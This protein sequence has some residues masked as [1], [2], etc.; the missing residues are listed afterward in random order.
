[1][2]MRKVL[3]ALSL[4]VMALGGLAQPA[5]ADDGARPT[6][7]FAPPDPNALSPELRKVYDTSVRLLGGPYGPRMPMLQSPEVANEWSKLLDALGGTSLSKRYWEIGILAVARIRNSPFEWWAHAQN[8]VK[9]GVPADEIEA[10][11]LGKPASFKDPAD[12]KI[13]RYASALIANAP[14]SD[15]VFNEAKGVLGDKDLLNLTILIGYYD[16]VAMVLKTYRMDVPP[17]SS[18]VPVL[19]VK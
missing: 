9:L 8:A 7:R 4:T 2:I 16:T 13:Y 12:A 3:F 14:V 1:V 19:V 17:K 11:R 6:D 10:L 15:R 5:F 18:T